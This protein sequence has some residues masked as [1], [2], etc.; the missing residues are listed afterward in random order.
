[1]SPEWILGNLLAW[2]GQVALLMAAALLASLG[3]RD[4][5]TRVWFWHGVLAVA[6]LLPLAMPWKQTPVEAI[7]NLP[8]K[9]TPIVFQAVAPEPVR[10]GTEEWI[11][12]AL[13]AGCGVRALVIAAGLARLAFIRRRAARI[14]GPGEAHWLVS[15]DISGP[16]T[17]GWLRPRVL[18]PKRI[19]AL[20]PQERAAIESH[21]LIHVE[22]RD[23]LWVIGEEFVRAIA[24]FHPGIWL[25][26]SQIQLAREQAVDR[27]VVRRTGNREAYVD[28]LLAV[29][30]HRLEPDLAPAPLF[31]K[32]RQLATRV[33]AVIREESMSKFEVAGRFLAGT[34]AATAAVLL[35]TFAFPLATQAQAQPDGQGITVDAGGTLLHRGPITMASGRGQNG[36]VLL[37]ATLS[38]SGDVLDAHVVSGPDELRKEALKSVLAWHYEPNT[39]TPVRIAVRYDAPSPSAVTVRREAYPQ[40]AVPAPPSAPLSGMT[41][42]TGRPLPSKDWIGKV[43]E[44][45]VGSLSEPLQKR[46]MER[47]PVRVGDSIT[48]ESAQ[49]VVEAIEQVDEHLRT[50]LRLAPDGTDMSIGVALGGSVVPPTPPA[51]PAPAAVAQPAVPASPAAPTRIRIG[52]NV[53]AANLLVKV[54]PT[55]PPAAKQARVQG[56]VKMEASIDTTGRVTELALISGDPL[57]VPAAT[58]AVSKWVYKPTLLN[59][60]PVEVVTQVDVNFTLAQ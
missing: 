15:D 43:Q 58:D 22:R 18:L 49:K 55:Y 32:K 33:A 5:R 12:W 45:S 40:G 31:L 8:G 42:P 23:W 56:V 28:A 16:V 26:L 9:L 3:W 47:I 38:R 14:E 1:M 34:A 30:A 59:D 51:P 41:N 48:M 11:L 19:L 35:A 6:M 13:V 46:V 2:C 52:G 21:E 36:I 53:Q 10:L 29:A 7:P 24:W 44:I 50:T 17:F 20:P 25:A 39:P 54:T 4:A 57:L 37:E 27:E 60:K